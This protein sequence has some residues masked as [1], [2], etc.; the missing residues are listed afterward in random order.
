MIS[1]SHFQSLNLAQI[2]TVNRPIL[3]CDYVPYTP[4]SLNLVNR[5]N[6]Y[7]FGKSRMDSVFFVKDSYLELYFKLIHTSAGNTRCYA[8]SELMRLVNLGCIAIYKI[9]RLTGSG[10]GKETEEVDKAHLLRLLCKSKSENKDID[11]LSIGFHR[12]IET[13]EKEV[14]RKKATKVGFVEHQ[15][16]IT[17]ALGY[18]VALPGS[19]DNLVLIH[20]DGAATENLSLAERVIIENIGWYVPQN[21][22]IIT[23][24]FNE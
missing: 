19:G 10:T 18:K 21:I 17:Y 14:N 22:P 11:D 2:H 23:T 8:D 1:N 16:N 9:Y 24:K 4:P 20:V 3:K 13:R 15:G 12:N 7:F 5:R 6:K